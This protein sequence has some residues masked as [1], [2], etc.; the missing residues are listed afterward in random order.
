MLCY[1]V[2]GNTAQTCVRC[3]KN[4][5]RNCCTS[6]FYL[7]YFSSPLFSLSFLAT[8]NTRV[9]WFFARRCSQIYILFS[10]CLD[11][12]ECCDFS[13]FIP[14]CY[15]TPECALFHFRRFNFLPLSVDVR[16][17]QFVSV[18]RLCASDIKQLD[19]SYS[20]SL[21]AYFSNSCPVFPPSHLFPIIFV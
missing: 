4:F 2:T 11:A 3:R 10:S 14:Y 19:G 7:V 12:C 9:G 15:Q 6:S 20:A 8:E 18:S 1:V 21:V 16:R 17:R 5:W 13:P